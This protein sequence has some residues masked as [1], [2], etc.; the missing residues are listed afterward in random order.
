MC[1]QLAEIEALCQALFRANIHEVY[2]VRRLKITGRGEAA[3][4]SEE[5]FL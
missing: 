1:Y 4:Q 2:N 3:E 5:D